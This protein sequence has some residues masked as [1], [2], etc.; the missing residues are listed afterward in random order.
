MGV[1]LDPLA[2]QTQAVF[3]KLGRTSGAGAGDGSTAVDASLAGA[4]GLGGLYL[5]LNPNNPITAEARQISSVDGAGAATL[6][7][8]FSA[9]VPS[10][11]PYAITNIGVGA[12][13]TGVNT[14]SPAGFGGNI[15]INDVIGN[16][17]DAAQYSVG[18]NPSEMA[19]I[20]GL[21]SI[22]GNPTAHTLTTFTAKWG[23]PPQPLATMLGDSSGHTLVGT[24]AKLGN[25]SL[26]LNSIVQPL[27][28]SGSYT[29]TADT[30]IE[31]TL[32]S[33]IPSSGQVAI[34][35]YV[36]IDLNALTQNATVSVQKITDNANW[37]YY[38]RVA[39]AV[40]G[41]YTG[42]QFKG[43]FVVDATSRLRIRIVSAA[44][45]GVNRSLPYRYYYRRVV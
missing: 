17:E 22:L 43:P 40:G 8:A 7:K 26:G 25:L 4:V 21:L 38:E 12:G 37:R 29:F 42:V 35:E 39:Y 45:E 24:N 5:V 2:R 11:T 32:L 13:G 28:I 36:E 3:L 27:T 19:Y 44:N 10:G 20:K 9:Q 31:Q 34:L 6:T 14:V 1:N 33:F 30:T 18:T 16:K 23:N 15:T 41:G